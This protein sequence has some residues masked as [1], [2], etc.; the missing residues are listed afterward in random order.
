MYK[1]LLLASYFLLQC[2]GVG[3]QSIGQEHQNLAAF[4]KRMYLAAPFEGVKIVEDYDNQYLI[5]VIALEK[6][7]YPNPSVMSRV[8]SMKAQAQASNF[9]NGAQINAETIIKTT[10][11]KDTSGKQQTITETIEKIKMNSAGFVQGMQLLNSFD[12]TEP[13]TIF[14]YSSQIQASKP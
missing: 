3:A 1:H 6:A 7:K 8:A 13:K 2:L 10:E 11:S 4:L 14:I 12:A 9:L 5:S